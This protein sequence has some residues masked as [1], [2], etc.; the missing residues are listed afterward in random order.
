M[1]NITTF[2]EVT[3]S[4]N[5]GKTYHC[6][7]GCNVRGNYLLV[8][9]HCLAARCYLSNPYFNTLNSLAGACLGLAGILSGFIK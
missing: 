4:T 9:G 7:F 5:G 8:Y 3:R 2:T 1:K 6:P